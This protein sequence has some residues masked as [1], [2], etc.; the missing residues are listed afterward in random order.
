[1][2]LRPYQGEAIQ[3]ARERLAHVR[4]VILKLATGLGKTIIAGGIIKS[5][6][7]KGKRTLFMAHTTELVLQAGDKIGKFAGVDYGVEKAEM[8]A[9]DTDHPMVLASVQ[10]LCKPQRLAR[11]APDFFDLI[12]TDEV[13]RGA[14]DSYVRIYDHF[15]KA[16][17]IGLTA[18]PFRSDDKSLGDVYDEVCFDFG[19]EEGVDNGWLVPIHSE[20]IP[21]KIDM[22]NVD[23]SGLGYKGSDVEDAITPVFE[24]VAKELRE[25]AGDK[26]LVVFLPV[27]TASKKFVEVLKEYGFDAEHVDGKSKDRAEI[28][29]RFEAKGPGSALCCSQLLKEGWDCITVDCVVVLSPDRSTLP[30]IQKV[31]RGTRPVD[32]EINEP[33]LTAD[34]RRMIIAS[35]T[36]PFLYLPD[37]LWHGATHDLCHPAC[38]FAKTEE[39]AEKMTYLQ[40]KGGVKDLQ[41]LEEEAHKELVSE[42]EEALAQSLKAFMGSKSKKFDPVLQS[43]SLIDDSLVNWSPETKKE[44]APVSVEQT[45]YLHKNGFDASG[46]KAGYAARVIKIMQDRSAKGLC[47][48]KQVRCLLKNGFPKA[49]NMTKEEASTAMDGLSKKWK[50]INK[51]K[52]KKK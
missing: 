14:S 29:A 34:Q 50:K 22:S 12:I 37:F 46:W 3:K 16:R 41:Q 38:L 11:F 15:K 20:T 2:K 35:G 51:W 28:L 27:I 30:Y 13:H 36:K 52:G 23:T 33:G 10:S 9:H 39:V 31:G 8:T 49:H 43:V 47:S 1:M 25:R 5:A 4:A 24:A 18:T 7:K 19:L 26:K 44:A 6:A 40:T 17:L 45:A 21:L 32:P 42:R 48:P